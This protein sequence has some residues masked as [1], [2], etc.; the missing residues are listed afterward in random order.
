MHDTQETNKLQFTVAESR[1]AVCPTCGN[2]SEF[3]LCG[4]QTWP[5]KVAQ[6]AGLPEVISVWQ[7]LTCDTTLLEPNLN[8]DE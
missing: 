8:F 2:H 7:C 1:S 5:L 6:A 3:V 4:V